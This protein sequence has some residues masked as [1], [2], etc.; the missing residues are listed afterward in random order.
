MNRPVP[1]PEPS[2]PIP[3]DTAARIRGTAPPPAPRRPAALLPVTGALGGASPVAESTD[4]TRAAG[5]AECWYEGCTLE[6]GV[7]FYGGGPR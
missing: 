6:D 2:T 3:A 1:T 7:W 5:R 4:G